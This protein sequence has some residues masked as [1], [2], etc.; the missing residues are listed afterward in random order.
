MQRK[1]GQAADSQ[2]RHQIRARRAPLPQPRDVPAGKQAR[3]GHLNAAPPRPARQAGPFAGQNAADTG[4]TGSQPGPL[5]PALSGGATVIAPLFVLHPAMGA[6]IAARRLPAPWRARAES[7]LAHV[8]FGLGPA[9]L[10]PAALKGAQSGA[11][12]C[13]ATAAPLRAIS[14]AAAR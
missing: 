13:R 9:A 8:T 14:R 4:A 5:W 11:R 10:A 6:G 12:I 7:L 2:T 1:P 3:A